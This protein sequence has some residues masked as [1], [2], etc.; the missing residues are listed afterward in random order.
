MKITSYEISFQTVCT[1]IAIVISIIAIILSIKN[2]NL[3]EA[4]NEIEIERDNLEYEKGKVALLNLISKYF[5]LNYQRTEF[6]GTNFRTRTESSY[7]DNYVKEI[8]MLS[9]Q[10]DNLIDNPYYTKLYNKYPF[11]GSISLFLRKEIMFLNKA[12]SENKEYGYDHDVWRI[13]Y[14][15]FSN[16]R[17]EISSKT[18]MNSEQEA[19]A[20]EEL[21]AV[22]EYAEKVNTYLNN[23]R[24]NIH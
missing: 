15:A 14:D 20:S 13:M 9:Q 5:I 7:S 19:I 18:R 21:K 11:I 1:V 4:L 12:K 22:F 16:L 10:F 17:K 24:N 6:N 23:G 3:S 2:N 8:E